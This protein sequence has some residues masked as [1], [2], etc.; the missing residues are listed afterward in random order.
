MKISNFSNGL[1]IWFKLCDMTCEKTTI[2]FMK[3]KN[4]FNHF[5]NIFTFFKV[6]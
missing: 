4:H 3:V 1:Q 6:L 5:W 2:N